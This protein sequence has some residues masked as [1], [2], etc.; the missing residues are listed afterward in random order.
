[1]AESGLTNAQEDRTRLNA[2]PDNSDGRDADNLVDPVIEA[3]GLAIERDCLVAGLGLEQEAI[4]AIRQG[5]AVDKSPD[6][7]EHQ[8][9]PRL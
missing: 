8:N 5:D 2:P 7:A 3:C 6:L 4:V 9:S 1:M